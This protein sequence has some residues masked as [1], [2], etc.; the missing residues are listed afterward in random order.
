MP[1]YTFPQDIPQFILVQG[2]GYAKKLARRTDPETSKTAARNL[3]KSGAHQDAYIRVYESL[4][5]FPNGANANEISSDNG[6]LV[7]VIHKR[8]N[9]LKLKGMASKTHEKRD[10][11]TVWKAASES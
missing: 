4:K 3:V 8:L 11:Q 2:R 1:V 6:M 9:C 10:N 7:H 5:K